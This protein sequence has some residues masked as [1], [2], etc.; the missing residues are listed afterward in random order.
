MSTR[1]QSG[2]IKGQP[3]ILRKTGASKSEIKQPGAGVLLAD[4]LCRIISP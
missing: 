1:T 3:V 4:H 2:K